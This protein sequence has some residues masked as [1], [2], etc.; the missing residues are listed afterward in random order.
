MNRRPT[1]IAFLIAKAFPTPRMRV[2]QK[3]VI[4][5][6][7][8]NLSMESACGGDFSK[9]PWSAKPMTITTNMILLKR[10]THKDG[11]MT[12]K[13]MDGVELMQFQGWDLSFYNDEEDI[14]DSSFLTQLAGNMFNGFQMG[15]FVVATTAGSN[16][17]DDVVEV[18]DGD[19]SGDK[20][21]CEDLGDDTD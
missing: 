17:K 19:A 8:L 16:V 1:E 12:F 18:K 15:S 2:T 20:S 21:S 13:I 7:D 10:E 14:P 9:Y 6:V 3:M 11:A 4:E 5:W